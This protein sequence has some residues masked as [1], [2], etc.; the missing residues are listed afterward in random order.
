MGVGYEVQDVSDNCYV[1]VGTLC[2][3]GKRLPDAQ[4]CTFTYV[5]RP[6]EIPDVQ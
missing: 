3:G 6:T 5:F 4:A 1:Y 2:G